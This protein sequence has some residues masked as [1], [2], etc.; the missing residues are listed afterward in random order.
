M[1]S[2]ISA[3]GRLRRGMR[4]RR[5]QEDSLCLLEPA[6]GSWDLSRVRLIHSESFGLVR[7]WAR[8]Q[9][10]L[11]K[12]RPSQAASFFTS[13]AS[14]ALTIHLFICFLFAG[15]FVC[16]PFAALVVSEALDPKR[17]TACHDLCVFFESHT[18]IVCRRSLHANL[19][20]S[21][22]WRYTWSA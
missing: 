3:C 5:E 14:S 12:L 10:R 7:L 13:G 17:Q 8:G 6:E 11:G 19:F 9:A 2:A 16:L 15:L 20:G 4:K 1:A 18:Y 21:R 22:L